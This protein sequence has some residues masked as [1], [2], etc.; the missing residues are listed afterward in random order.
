VYGTFK[1]TVE[2]KDRTTLVKTHI[3][4]DKTRI[5]ASEYPAFRS[6]CEQVDA[7]LNQRIAFTQ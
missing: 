2:T 6:Y 4:I 3:T 1:I 5:S 7:A